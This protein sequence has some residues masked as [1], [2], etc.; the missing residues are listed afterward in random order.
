[1]VIHS[2]LC[3]PSAPHHSTPFY[4]LPDPRKNI[5]CFACKWLQNMRR[6]VNN[7]TRANGW[8][9]GFYSY[10]SLCRGNPLWL[11]FVVVA[12]FV[13]FRGCP[14]NVIAIFI[15][16][17][18]GQHIGQTQGPAPTFAHLFCRLRPQKSRWCDI[19][20]INR[21]VF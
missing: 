1:L 19:P 16:R 7:R 4:H 14:F 8:I 6:I 17:S 5:F 11:P 21:F 20:V 18:S 12:H 15:R 13:G 10:F 3:L 2:R 9:D